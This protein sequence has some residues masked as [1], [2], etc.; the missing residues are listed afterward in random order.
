MKAVFF[1]R[2]GELDVLRYG[3]VPDPR[4]GPNEVVI[5]VKAAA[6]NYNDIWARRGLPRV[7]LPLPHVSGT[8]GAGVVVEVGPEVEGVAA[9]DEVLTYPVNACRRCPACLAGT[10][11]FCR[12]MRIWGFQTGPYD[13]SFAQ[14]ARVQAAQVAP[15]PANL[16]WEEAAATSTSLLSVWRMLV[17][18]AETLP[19]DTV[20]IW[21]ASGGTGSYAI[22]LCRVLGAVPIAI[23]SSE[24]KAEFC[25]SMGAEHVILL[26]REDV[27]E[28]VRELTDGRG[29]DVAFDHVGERSW[30]ISIECLRWGGKL[31][32]CGATTGFLP[33]TDLRYLWNKQLSFLGSHIG[34]HR[35]WLDCLRLVH[36]G[37]IRPPV[38][39]TF[40][41]ADL[42]QAQ[43]LMEERGVTGKI[44]IDCT[45]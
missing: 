43:R 40:P 26:G 11:V 35:E 21:G 45:T 4:P 6:C 15:R 10:E 31:V 14:Y 22:Q 34:T 8:D 32:I 23:T 36:Q 2:H 20:L 13:G 38:T 1:E 9:G 25:R 28:R 39:H 12:K 17:T 18:R 16:S 27:H 33:Q 37:R 3:D 41:L 19:G 5:E 24:E 29:V 44:A 42:A 7:E 30:P